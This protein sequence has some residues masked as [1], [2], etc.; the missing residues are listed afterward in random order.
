MQPLSH[1]STSIEMR[2]GSLRF[3]GTA[4]VSFLLIFQLLWENCVSLTGWSP[5]KASTRSRYTSLGSRRIFPPE[6]YFSMDAFFFFFII[7]A[8]AWR[9]ACIM[10]CAASSR[11]VLGGPGGGRDAR[12]GYVEEGTLL[13]IQ[14]YRQILAN[15]FS[16]RRQQRAWT[17][18]PSRPQKL[19][20]SIFTSW[21]WCCG[22]REWGV[23]T[24]AYISPWQTL[25]VHQLVTNSH[26]ENNILSDTQGWTRYFPLQQQYIPR[27]ARDKQETLVRR[28]LSV[29]HRRAHRLFRRFSGE[30]LPHLDARV[31]DFSRFRITLRSLRWN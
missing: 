19:Y 2:A 6:K 8:T 28:S 27:S 15:V 30:F 11:M 22:A 29:A 25:A 12:R 31:S 9:D 1:M 23:P 17:N 26:G 21:L 20:S 5:S 7:F 4:L 14:R 16:R 13:S 24:R 10:Q 18:Q 3:C